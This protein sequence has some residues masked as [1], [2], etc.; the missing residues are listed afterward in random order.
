[1]KKDAK[2]AAPA[3]KE[4]KAAAPAKDA[5]KKDVKSA[6]KPSAAAAP[7]KKA[8][9]AKVEKPVAEK[10]A[11]AVVK[12]AAAKPKKSVTASAA[13]ASGKVG[14]RAVLRGK[15]L[16]KKKVSLRYAIDCTNIAEDNIL[17]VAD[18]V[19]M[20][21]SIT[22]KNIRLKFLNVIQPSRQ[23]LKLCS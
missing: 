7:V 1:M 3:K 5:P 23:Y 8:E 12:P 10:A 13:V 20:N 6:G 22:E 17:D 9:P 19:S 18:F 21:T 15:G 4:A 11:K 2:A 14:K 16:K